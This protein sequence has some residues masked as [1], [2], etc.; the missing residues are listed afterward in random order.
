MVYNYVGNL[1]VT[2]AFMSDFEK[3]Y[4]GICQDWFDWDED[5]GHNT[6]IVGDEYCQDCGRPKDDCIC[7]LFDICD[8]CGHCQDQCL[9]VLSHLRS[10][11]D[12]L[13]LPE[14]LF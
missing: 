10:K 6:E 5:C 14:A 9:Y 12:L 1:E 3:F 2:P 7:G 4:C 11:G 8:D 13:Y